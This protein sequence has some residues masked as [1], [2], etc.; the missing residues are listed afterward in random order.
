MQGTV[1]GEVT[2][3]SATAAD[4]SCYL[5]ITAR[6]AIRKPE[7]FLNITGVILRLRD[8]SRSLMFRE[9]FFFNNALTVTRPVL[10]QSNLSRPDLDDV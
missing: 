6:R 9:H 2:A 1:A 3:M 5:S 7:V 8:L 4:S 10:N